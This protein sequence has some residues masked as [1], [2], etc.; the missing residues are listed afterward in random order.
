[1]ASKRMRVNLVEVGLEK[2]YQT[3]DGRIWVYFHDVGF[4]T[5]KEDIR[6]GILGMTQV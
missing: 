2:C 6:V 5:D 4:S 3:A 1:M